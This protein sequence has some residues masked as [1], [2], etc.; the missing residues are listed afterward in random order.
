MPKDSSQPVDMSP[1]RELTPWSRSVGAIRQRLKAA[2]AQQ[3]LK[4]A[5]MAVGDR[6]GEVQENLAD[7]RGDRQQRDSER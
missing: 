6:A 1:E 2:L 5:A 7:A 3:R 4:E